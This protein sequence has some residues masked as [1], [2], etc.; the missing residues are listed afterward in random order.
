MAK[1]R[2]AIQLIEDMLFGTTANPVTI[3]TVA[4]DYDRGE[5]VLEISGADVPDVPE[6]WAMV[7]RQHNR[8][9]QRFETMTFKFDLPIAAVGLST[10]TVNCCRNNDIA[11]LQQLAK[12]SAAELLRIANFGRVS[13]LEVEE[14]LAKFG[15]EL[16]AD[17]PKISVDKLVE[18]AA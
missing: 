5:L 14:L 9:G 13:L 2:I 8:A 4:A 16:G 1:V 10:R 11:T 17:R 6:V 3:S 15:L 18:R 12:W 7:A